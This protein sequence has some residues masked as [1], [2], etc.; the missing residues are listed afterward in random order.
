MHGRQ[1]PTDTVAPAFIHPS[2]DPL[3]A[4]MEK[5]KA[6]KEDIRLLIN[7]ALSSI[8]PQ[9][10]S[11]ES[12]AM[13]QAGLE[14]GLSY[15]GLELEHGE[16][17]IA[18]IWGLYESSDPATIKYPER[19]SLKTD[20]EQRAEAD[21]LKKQIFTAASKT[22]QK[23]VVKRIAIIL[24]GSKIS[25]AALD[26]IL[27][28]IDKSDSITADPDILTQHLENALVSNKTASIA[29]GYPDNES[30]LAAEDHLQR[31]LRISKAQGVGLAGSTPTSDPGA[32]GV[33]D[34]S[35]NPA[36]STNEKIGKSQ[37]G[38]N[39]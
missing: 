15:I 20:S 21:S 37:R 16:R 5:Q 31:V 22:Y 27:Q 33:Q 34:F 9:M 39:A 13:D 36:A 12:K 8:R 4:S 11:A 19:Y 25:S 14:S 18:V 2:T 1:Y 3:K 23:E 7:L 10:A 32:R 38:P 6:L 29:S 28:E 24:L 17:Q 26:K 35:A 30:V